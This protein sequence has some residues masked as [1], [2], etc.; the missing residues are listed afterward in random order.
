[1]ELP[2]LL[3]AGQIR[4]LLD[5]SFPTDSDLD[6]FMIDHYPQVKRRFSA[7][8]DRIAKI[9][10]LLE[11]KDRWDLSETLRQAIPSAFAYML[12]V[13]KGYDCGRQYPLPLEGR[14]VIGRGVD[15]DLQLR[16]NIVSRRHLLLM[17]SSKGIVAY[18]E[19]KHPIWVDDQELIANRRLELGC[20]LYIHDIILALDAES[21]V[22]AT[23]SK[24][25]E[26]VDL[27]RGIPMEQSPHLRAM[28]YRKYFDDAKSEARKGQ[29]IKAKRFFERALMFLEMEPQLESGFELYSLDCYGLAELLSSHGKH[30]EAESC[31]RQAIALLEKDSP[32]HRWLADTRKALDLLLTTGRMTD[33]SK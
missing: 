4:S 27:T 8:M 15:V 32:E 21:V 23:D 12:T 26:P 24:A 25:E 22:R 28:L 5:R 31:L 17:I 20:H 7:A 11:L 6:A 30:K 18:K 29:F 19:G 10:L 33:P 3:T 13:V 14:F 2:L 9:N 16:S 1:M